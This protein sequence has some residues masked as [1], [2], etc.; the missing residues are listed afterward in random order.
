MPY[1]HFRQEADRHLQLTM[2]L[3]FFDFIM[4]ELPMLS[5]Y[6]C[7]MGWVY[8]SLNQCNLKYR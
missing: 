4:L 7:C 6:L 8:E 1:K 3:K 2:R 5:N